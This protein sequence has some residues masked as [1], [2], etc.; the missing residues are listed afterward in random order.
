MIGERN[1]GCELDLGW[2]NSV[3]INLS[4]VNNLAQKLV[5]C[6]ELKDEYRA[7]WL[8]KAVTCIDL[9]T[10]AGDDTH[11][12]VS[13]LC[14]KAAKPIAEDLLSQLG[15]EYNEKSPIHTAAVCVYSSKVEDAVRTLKKMGMDEKVKVASVATGFPSGQ[16]PLKTRLEEIRYAVEKGAKEIDIVI[17]RSLVL[18]GKWETLYQEIQV[19]KEACGSHSHMKA[20]LA[21]GEL[22]TLENVYKA[23]LVAM[24]AGSDFIKTSTGKEAVNAT[25]PFGIVMSRAI[26]EYFEKM[27]YKVGL[28]PAGGVRSAQDA[29]SWLILVKELLGNDWL[30]PELFRFGASGLL[31]DLECSLYQYVTGKIPAAY[32]F[33]MG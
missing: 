2:I 3:N 9:T 24:M 14:F 15:F 30:T 16:T 17:D 33:S 22:G 1:P 8:L 25:L 4:A 5:K 21:T 12:N 32:E 6:R 26:K 11:S 19:M 29:I 10:L 28:K 7:A 13:R 31:G 27:G 18:T 20:I 23:S